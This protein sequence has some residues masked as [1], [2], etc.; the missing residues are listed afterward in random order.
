M[1]S[2]RVLPLVVASVV[3]LGL[4]ACGSDDGPSTTGALAAT[5][6]AGASGGAERTTYPLTLRNNCGRDVTVKAAPGRAVSVNQGSTEIL[7]SLGLADRMV[8]TATWT[9]RIRPNL[10]A[11][12]AKVPRLGDDAVSYERILKTEPDLVSASFAYALNGDDPD[13]R[14]RFAKL[15]VPTYLAPSHCENRDDES[16]DGPRSKPLQLSTIST[17]IRQLAQIFD[18]RPKGEALVAD[19]ERRLEKVRAAN[20]SRD[21]EEISIAYWF[22]NTESPYVAG[23]CG[24]SGIISRTAGV[25][26]VFADTKDEFPQV[27]WETVLDR[28]PTV[29][30]LGDLQRK[31]QTGDKLADKIRFLESDPVTKRLTAVRKRRY[32][33]LNGA[34]MN[35]SIRTVDGAEKVSAGI[36]KLGLVR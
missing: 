25:R 6:T 36:R 22:A 9:D 16:G 11:A 3:A 2:L 26:N 23:C 12:N 5:D 19:L 15:G 29:L 30:V 20:A 35:P 1:S 4:T 7:L 17:E 32:V 14:D 27:G 21:P 18:V 8:G 34:D 28:D 13:R 33:I 31:S 10:A 24:S